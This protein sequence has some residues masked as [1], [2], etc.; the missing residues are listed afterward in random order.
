M[1]DEVSV[2]LLESGAGQDMA[3]FRE[4]TDQYIRKHEDLPVIRKVRW[5][6]PLTPDDLAELEKLLIAAGTVDE[7]DKVKSEV[8]L[9][10]FVRSM[11]FCDTLPVAPGDAPNGF[12]LSSSRR[13]ENRHFGGVKAEQVKCLQSGE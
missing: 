13:D 2:E 5:N 12:S 1:G 3:R 7:L 9:G 4:K 6:E 10:L 8:G 11:G